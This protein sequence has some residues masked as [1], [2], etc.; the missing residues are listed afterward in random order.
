MSEN[1]KK[2]IYPIA[3]F[4]LLVGSA[5]TISSASSN[6]KISD[7][8]TIKFESKD[9]T[10][11]FK[12][13][14]GTIKFDEND[15]AAAKFDLSFEVASIS[16]GNGMKNKKALTAEWFDAAKHPQITYVS[17]KVE[18]SGSDYL[19]TGTLK[20]KGTAKEQKVPLKVTKNGKE[21]TF[22]GSFKVNRIDFKVGKSAPAVPD[23]MNI[24]YSIPVT[25]N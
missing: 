15:L 5:A 9:P 20:M 11:E 16:T 13:M 23:V 3:A 19:V 25:Q 10:G 12:V 8:Y 17:S 18:K 4:V 24:S 7:G 22:T 14:K 6:L 2:F 21:L 1:M